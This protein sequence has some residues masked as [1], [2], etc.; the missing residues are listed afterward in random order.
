MRVLTMRQQ[1]TRR[2]T[3]KPATDV[4]LPVAAVTARSL[5][6]GRNGDMRVSLEAVDGERALCSCPPR[7]G[8]DGGGDDKDR[9]HRHPA[10]LG[11]ASATPAVDDVHRV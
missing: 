10:L 7:P 9:V 2:R 4:I 3:I 5:P 8:Q 6:H 1:E 11:V